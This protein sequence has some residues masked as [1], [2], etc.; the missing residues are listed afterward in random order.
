M[1]RPIGRTLGYVNLPEAGEQV[2]RAGRRR[3]LAAS[4]GLKSAG[5]S[6]PPRPP[7]PSAQFWSRHRRATPVD[8]AL[9]HNRRRRRGELGLGA[10][11]R[12]VI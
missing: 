9:F 7:S 4:L 11:A 6:G 10:V 3:V 1:L 8:E 12:A 5:R 2:D